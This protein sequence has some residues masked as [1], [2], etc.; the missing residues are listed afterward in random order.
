MGTTKLTPGQRVYH[1]VLGACRVLS[2]V[3]GC[4]VVVESAHRRID[5]ERR[6]RGQVRRKTLLRQKDANGVVE[7]VPVTQL[8]EQMPQD[9][10][11]LLIEIT[12]K[13]W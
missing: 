10:Q 13:R 5:I 11:Q 6:V 9:K 7:T 12:T 8:H 4:D 2:S 3:R 1:R